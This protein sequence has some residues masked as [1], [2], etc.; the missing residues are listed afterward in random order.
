MTDDADARV[1]EALAT[2]GY[3][4]FTTMLVTDRRVRGL[5]L[6]LDRLA[7]DGRAVFGAGVDGPAVR[8]RIRDAAPARGRRIVR[9]TVADPALGIGTIGAAAAPRPVVTTRA[10]P[11]GPAAALRV[12]TAVHR[13]YLPEV[14]STG[15]FATLHLRR[16]AVRDG[17]DDV[18]LT[19]GDGTLL[20]G[21]TWNVGLVT[22]DRIVWPDGPVL[23]GT[24]RA[25]LR[26]VLDDAGIEQRDATVGAGDLTGVDAVFATSATGVRPIASIDTHRFDPGHPLLGRLQDLYEAIPGT[27]L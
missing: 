23:A 17:V 4:H 15:L 22:G 10:A 6:H 13:R 9:V 5:Q 18:L 3:G 8:S 2:T 20:E 19:T 14:K 25:L 7:R 21:S 11:P 27:V 1:L 12:R 16:L 24:T 26:G